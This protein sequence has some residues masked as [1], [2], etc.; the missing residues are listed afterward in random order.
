M[1]ATQNTQNEACRGLSDLTVRLDTCP[2][3][4]EIP[5][6]T[7]QIKSSQHE[8]EYWPESV[9]CDNCKIYFRSEN[10]FNAVEKWNTRRGA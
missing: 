7:P 8:G 1:E 2:F 3:C 10:G 5:K 6:H 9:V 4:G